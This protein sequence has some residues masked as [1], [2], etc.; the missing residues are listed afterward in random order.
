MCWQL[1]FSL[2]ASRDWGWLRV[3]GLCV[4]PATLSHPSA[5][6]PSP[7]WRQP[8]VFSILLSSGAW[9]QPEL[10]SSPAQAQVFYLLGFEGLFPCK[11]L[12]SLCIESASIFRVQLL[13]SWWL[14]MVSFI[15]PCIEHPL[16]LSVDMALGHRVN[17]L[18]MVFPAVLLAPYQSLLC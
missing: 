16:K 12:C 9:N 11:G 6:S 4:L 8:P 10:T 5:P 1:S 15:H 17:W 7:A 2:A 14:E 3:L 18:P 13:P